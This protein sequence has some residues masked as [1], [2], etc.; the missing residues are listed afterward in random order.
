MKLK[1]IFIILIVLLLAAGVMVPWIA[2]NGVALLIL[3]EII[4]LCAIILLIYF[5]K[6]A[7]K[8]MKSIAN[9]MDLLKEQDFSS[10]LKPIGQ[11][12]ADRIVQVFN[13]MMDQ[14]KDERLRLQEQNHLL[15]LLIEVSPMGVVI[16]DFDGRITMVND[17]ALHF[18]NLPAEASVKGLK[19]EELHSPLSE[20]I[21]LIPDGEARTIR[22]SDARIYR[23]SRLSF[24]DRGFTHPFVLI[25][26][27]TS[28]V[29]KAEKKAYEKVI[30]MIAHEVNNTIGGVTS[31]LETIKD[32][33]GDFDKGEDLQ[34]MMQVCIERSLG[35]SRFITQFA[36]VVKIPEPELKEVG[37]ND[38]VLGCKVFLE[39]LGSDRHIEFKFELCGENPKVSMDQVLFEQVLV[40]IVKNAVESF[41]ED[42]VASSRAISIKTAA[43]EPMLVI[44]DNGSPIPREVETKLFTPFF[45]TKPNGQGIGLLFIREVLYRHGC[46]FSLRSYDDGWT[47]FCISF[48]N[49]Q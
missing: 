2:D 47:R 15:D 22:L 4:L 31:G 12:E 38:F 34:E 27:L 49:V 33:L 17:A 26:S 28:E 6:K 7:V 24:M 11:K 13:R 46:S 20:E 29:V 41:A 19:L 3:V 36:D 30:R 18:M 21:A 37:L 32:I 44:A 23:C 45:S 1:H 39:T 10:R 42:E 14:M 40:N 16:Q 25:E 5:Y 43:S 35:M 48:K 8:P 9:G